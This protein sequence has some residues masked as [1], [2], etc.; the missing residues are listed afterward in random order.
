[1]GASQTAT[2]TESKNGNCWVADHTRVK[3]RIVRHVKSAFVAVVAAAAVFITVAAAEFWWSGHVLDRELREQME[4]SVG[5]GGIGAVSVDVN[6]LPATIV[7]LAAFVAVFV[8]RE[9][10]GQR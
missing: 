5:S 8:W 2:K 4:S 6:V 7:S 3:W 9:R 10:Q 1:M